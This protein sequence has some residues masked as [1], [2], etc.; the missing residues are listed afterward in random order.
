MAKSVDP[1][2]WCEGT[3][4]ELKPWTERLYSIRIDAPVDRFTAGQ[5]TKLGLMI[6][7][8]FISRPYSYVNAPDERPLEFYFITVPEGPLTQRMVTLSPGDAIYVM[9]KAAGFLT[10][11]EVPESKH[12]WMLSTGTAIG[13]F[14]SILKTPDP[15][16]RFE[17]IVLVHAVRTTAELSFQD[18][19]QTIATSHPDQFSYIPFVSREDTDFAIRDRI[20]GALA[21]GA[22]EARAGIDITPAQSQVMICGNPAMVKD[23][24]D[25]LKARGLE[26]NR[27]RTPGHI[28]VENY[29]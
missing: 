15:W 7:D 19:I 1:A 20:P 25:A 9:R 2:R 13:P 8:E 29:W 28:T 21:S 10:L 22:L 12:L 26:R 14:L 6:D 4:Q 23:T 5:F 11:A 27:R 16:K 17:R 24:S 3:V 18:T